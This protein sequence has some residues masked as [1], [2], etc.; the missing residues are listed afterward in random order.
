MRNLISERFW[1]VKHIN[2]F[3]DLSE[4]DAR[5]L[6]QITTFK[7]LKHEERI[8]TEGV[9]LIKEGRIK[10]TEN[11][12]VPKTEKPEINTKN[13]DPDE[14]QQT[15]EVLEQGEM[16]GFVPSDDSILGENIPCYAE[17]LSDVCLGVVTIRDFSFFLKRKPHVGLPLLYLKRAKTPHVFRKVHNTFSYGSKNNENWHTHLYKQPASN[18]LRKNKTPD[19]LKFNRFTNIAFRCAS[20]RFALLLHNLADTPD[21]KGVVLV[22]RLSKKRISRLIGSSTE[23]IET[24]LNTFKQYDVIKKRRG[25]IQVLNPWHLKKIADASM[26]TLTAPTVPD[27]APD[28]DF[29]LE[30]LTNLSNDNSI[31]TD[32]TVSKPQTV[33]KA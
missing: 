16:F 33:T 19:T 22:P 20:S 25:R 27:T 1:C 24:L 12:R 3:R 6:E 15:K 18:I 5:A 13:T 11:S 9:C 10:I 28:D 23:T 7:H 4:T 14:K 2:I 32:S 30:L 8:C 29:G 21:S 31:Q 17:T 26:K